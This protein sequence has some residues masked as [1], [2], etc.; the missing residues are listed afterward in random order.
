MPPDAIP[1]A[2]PPVPVTIDPAELKA[3]DESFAVTN[4]P[5]NEIVLLQH[6]GD[7]SFA[8]TVRGQVVHA[9]PAQRPVLEQKLLAVLRRPEL[10]ALGRQ[11]VCRM[12]A[13]VGGAASVPA[14]TPLLA[15]PATADD[16][17]LALDAIDDPA[18]DAAYRDAL[19]RLRGRAR[20]GLIGSLALRGGD[21]TT[22]DVLTAIAIDAREPAET[23]DAAE[24]V[25]KRLVSRS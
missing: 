10:T 25:V 11:F 4:D 3:R 22:V 7:R 20:L 17:R 23:R 6:G 5:W 8:S 1:P 9:E 18:V 16:A 24:R 2:P 19:T 15:E 14:L 13:L 21:A 12:L